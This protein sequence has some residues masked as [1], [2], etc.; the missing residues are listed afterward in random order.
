MNLLYRTTGK[1]NR[2]LSRKTPKN[3]RTP[4]PSPERVQSPEVLVVDEVGY[5]PFDQDSA[6]LFFQ[7]VSSCYERASLILTSNLAFSRWADVFG[8]AT[9]ASAIID[10]IVH[11]AEV[12][13]LSGNSYRLQGRLKPQTLAQ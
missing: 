8:D 5:I 4:N 1:I 7:L 3:R 6:N 13:N 9:I 2:L 12:I 10:R 11:H